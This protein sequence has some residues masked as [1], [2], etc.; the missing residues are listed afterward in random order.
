MCKKGLQSEQ[1]VSNNECKEQSNDNN[2]KI[3]KIHKNIHKRST[4]VSNIDLMFHPHLNQYNIDLQNSLKA[5]IYQQHQKTLE[6]KEKN[7]LAAKK[8]REK[9]ASLLKS[10]CLNE[11]TLNR[12][13]LML[14][15][16]LDDYDKV[17]NEMLTFADLII[18]EFNFLDTTNTNQR[19]F[20]LINLCKLYNYL[21]KL[22]KPNRNQF[23][24]IPNEISDIKLR[25][26]DHKIS[27]LKHKIF[28]L[29]QENKKMRKCS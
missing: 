22:K 4:D 12:Q 18:N 25:V 13:I 10:Y 8:S 26:N 7:R 23:F 5:Q 2:D 14:K 19:D 15:E 16:L 6:K 17:L 28:L 27:E 29:F 1:E 21:N 11:I 20:R 24:W 9:K 3:H